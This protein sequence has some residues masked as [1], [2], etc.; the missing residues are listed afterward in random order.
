[1]PLGIAAERI[2]HY[3]HE[4]ST[5]ATE[6]IK[7]DYTHLPQP[8]DMCAKKILLVSMRSE[9][10]VKRAQAQ[11]RGPPLAPAEF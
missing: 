11:E 1:M 9:R 6:G 3:F 8:P 2:V 4:Y 5:I 7:L 10:R